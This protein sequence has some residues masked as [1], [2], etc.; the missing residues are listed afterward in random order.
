MT[1]HRE[2][3]VVVDNRENKELLGPKVLFPEHLVFLRP[4]LIRDDPST[5]VVA[6]RFE[7]GTLPTGDYL[8]KG[9]E[10]LTIGER[11]G[12][13]HEVA[14]NCLTPNGRRKFVACCQR[15]RDECEHPILLLEGTPY[16]LLKEQV[17][18]HCKQ[19]DAGVAADALMRLCREYGIELVL[20]SNDT[21]NHRRAAG[22]WL[23]RRMINNTLVRRLPNAT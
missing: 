2:Y 3:T 19:M 7:Y 8:L 5:Q 12:H 9:H 4:D 20:V 14:A 22:E 17:C 6:I 23:V 13:L 15:L 10:S 1:L 16:G 11:K 21:P 18:I